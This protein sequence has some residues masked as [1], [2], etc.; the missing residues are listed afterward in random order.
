VSQ[1]AD[2]AF[3]PI[4]PPRDAAR[5]LVALLAV[6]S[7]AFLVFYPPTVTIADEGNYVRQA[8]LLT[9][10]GGRTLE[11]VD[12]FTDETVEV[13]VINDYP[14][15]T[16]LL[17]VPF[18]A[19]GGRGAAHLLA[20]V[21][22]LAGVAFTARWL[23]EQQRSP[24]WAVLV[25]AYPATAIMG[26]V[27]MSEAPSL[28]VVAA[29]LWLYWRGLSGERASSLGAGFLAGF[30]LALR[31]AN[32]LL[33]APFFIGSVVRRDAGWPLL[34]AGSLAG[35]A[36][37]LVSAWLFFGDPLFLKQPAPFSL[38][39]ALVSAPIYLTCLLV[40]VPGGLFA[41]FAY[42]GERSAEVR[43]AIGV[44]VLFHLLYGYS[45]AES[46]LAKR[47]VLGPRYFI[48]LLPL[49]ALTAAEVWPRL[50]R[51]LWLRST[52]ERRDRLLRDARRAIAAVV[53]AV[54]LGL[55][56]VHVVH[57]SWAADQAEIR[58]AIYEATEDGSVIVANGKAI[59]KFMDHLYG[60]R[61]VIDRSRMTPAHLRQLAARQGRFFIVLLD[62]TDSAYWRRNAAENSDFMAS[63]RLRR[64]QLVDLR[65]T[66][67][68]H[69]RIWRVSE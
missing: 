55:V 65:V 18:V 34:A 8:Q 23:H 52:P 20:L 19:V 54:A 66:P 17:M 51:R 22:T 3:P 15:G 60:Q 11:V 49:L 32:V 44:F 14:L 46:G 33:F 25:L 47:L 24:L 1:A 63:L 26:R 2:A 41:A 12:P 28:M 43:L 7:L 4:L 58:D 57:W 59:G 35:V 21:C 30:S 31:E 45:A 29:G 36:V 69:L 27:A 68:D 48:P 40:L 13:L 62:R 6:Y 67:T 10:G 64:E 37:R 61:L 50:A 9:R 53:A 16:A 38:E 42:R 5:I 56:A 39:S